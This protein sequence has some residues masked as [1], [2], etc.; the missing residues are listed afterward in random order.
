[1]NIFRFY[2]N[3]NKEYQL[4]NDLTKA[5]AV[6]LQENNLILFEALKELFT[7]DDFNKVIN[8]DFNSSSVEISIQRDTKTIVNSDKVYA[9]SVSESTL[10]ESTFFSHSEGKINTEITDLVIELVIDNN[11]MWKPKTSLEQTPAT[12][13]RVIKERINLLFPKLLD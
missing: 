3:E 13:N 2:A 4:E 12:F 7:E 9:I 5:L 11:Q 10:D 8:S 1:M 6:T